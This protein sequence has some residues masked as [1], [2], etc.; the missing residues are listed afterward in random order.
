MRKDFAK[1]IAKARKERN[2]T[3]DEVAK[4]TGM[5]KSYVWELENKP[6]I[7]PSAMTVYKLAKHFDVTVEY[8]LGFE[9]KPSA[10]DRAFYQRY[11]NASDKVRA[12]IRHILG[13]LR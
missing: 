13:V 9:S 2:D 6:A 5:T 4:A 7:R 11:L 3:L 12:Q 8:L 1:T 10:I